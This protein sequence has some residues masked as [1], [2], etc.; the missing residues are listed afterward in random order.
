MKSTGLSEWILNPTTNVLTRD[1][2]EGQAMWLEI[3]V[4][5]PQA[6]VHMEPLEAERGKEQLVP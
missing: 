2:Q 6:K 5:Q 1:I 4:V 3:R